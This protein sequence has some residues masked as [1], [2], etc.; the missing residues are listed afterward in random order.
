MRSTPHTPFRVG[1]A[2]LHHQ[3]DVTQD[4]QPSQQQEHFFRGPAVRAHRIAFLD[5][6]VQDDLPTAP[7]AEIDIRAQVL[8]GLG[9]ALFHLHRQRLLADVIAPQDGL[10]FLHRRARVCR[11]PS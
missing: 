8:D 5:H 2:P 4:E 9:I 11:G 10:D 1:A 6:V 3:T 7:G